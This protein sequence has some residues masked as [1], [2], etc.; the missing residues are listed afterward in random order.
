MEALGPQA[1]PAHLLCAHGQWEPVSPGWSPG[2]GTEGGAGSAGQARPALG[3]ELWEEDGAQGG[4]HTALCACKTQM[5]DLEVRRLM[6]VA[7]Q[8]FGWIWR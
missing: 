3:G 4:A 5:R 1:Q 7:R 2:P 8:P 6:S